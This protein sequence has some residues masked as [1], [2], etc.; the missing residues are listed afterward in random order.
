MVPPAPPAVLEFDLDPADLPA[1]LRAPA[2]ATL[3]QGRAR[4]TR[5]R[6]VWHDTAAHGL[7]GRG[8]ALS[9]QGGQWRLERLVPDQDTIWLPASPAPVLAEAGTAADLDS[10]VPGQLAPVAAF[11]GTRRSIR[12]DHDGQAGRLD[13]LHGE[14]R[15]V[16]H[17]QPACRVR[18]T[19]EAPAM[20]SLALE[21]A[22]QA[23]LTVPRAGLAA[24]AMAIATGTQPAPRHT[25]GPQVPPGLNVDQAVVLI[26][27]HLADVILHWARTAPDGTAPEPVHQMRVA[28][29]RLRTALA[30]FRRTAPEGALDSLEK[31]LKSVAALLGGARDWDVFLGETGVAVHRAFAHDPRIAGLLGAAAKRRSAAYTELRAYLRGGEWRQLSLRL[32]L[33]PTLRPWAASLADADYRSLIEAP[34]EAYAAQALHRLFRRLAN[35]GEDL[36][37]LDPVALHGVRKQVK[38]LR[39]TTEFFAPLFPVKPVRRFVEKLVDLQQCLG[40]LNDGAVA[41]AMT[42]E[43]GSGRDR[44]FAAGVVQGYVAAANAAA[45]RRGGKAWRKLIALDKFWA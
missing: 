39:Y 17:D 41:A 3:R 40:G 18:L 5:L 19:G 25:G 37:A 10:Q 45:A 38:K 11:A 2:L 8:L 35:A 1:L 7:R 16:A 24:C 23:K 42:Q 36:A 29:R 30:V 26:T 22:G 14:L 13:V 15:G 20:A 4:T 28:V 9:E 33:L 12:L 34:T 31:E 27:A 21:L 44:A 32:A 6:T 43:L